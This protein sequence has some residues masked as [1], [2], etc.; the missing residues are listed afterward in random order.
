MH[1]IQ[2]IFVYICFRFYSC[3]YM[4]LVIISTKYNIS[5]DHIRRQ[6]SPRMA[7]KWLRFHQLRCPL[8]FAIIRQ[9]V[10]HSRQGRHSRS[11]VLLTDHY[12][13]ST[14]QPKPESIVVASAA[15]DHEENPSLVPLQFDDT[16]RRLAPRE[17]FSS[18]ILPRIS[19][20]LVVVA[21]IVNDPGVLLY[22]TRSCRRDDRSSFFLFPQPRRLSQRSL[23]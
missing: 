13:R 19:H 1:I 7:H 14:G 18:V 20:R 8:T 12:P 15:V 6:F 9:C 16:S 23:T 3:L 11:Y 21:I 10:C 4:F 2:R 5:I 22:C 17:S